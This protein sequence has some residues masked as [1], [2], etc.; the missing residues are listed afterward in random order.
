MPYSHAFRKLHRPT[1]PGEAQNKNQT[2]TEQH[3]GQWLPSY[4]NS[5]LLFENPPVDGASVNYRQHIMS[6]GPPSWIFESP[7][8]TKIYYANYARSSR[9]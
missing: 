2:A 7:T 8:M 6:S 4:S 3:D 5:R 9:N 1:E